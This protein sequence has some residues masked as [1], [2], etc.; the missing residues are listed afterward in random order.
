MRK[1]DTIERLYLDFDGFFASVE[2][3]ARPR[4]RGRP[5]GIVPFAGTR[6]TCVIACSKEAKA[7]GVKNVMAVAE[8]LR[9]C[10]DMVLAPQSPDL[11]R[12]AHNALLSEIAAVIPIAAVKSID[13]LTCDLESRDIRDPEGLASRIKRR[14]RDHVGP[15][16]TCSIG[17]AANRQLAKIAGKM[18]KP[19]GVTIWRPQD[20][21]G[22]LLPVPFAKIPGIGSR[23]E[24]R[25]ALAG[26]FDTAGLLALQ[27]KQMRKLWN[28][29]TGERLWYALHGYD[30]KT[31]PSRRGMFG[32]GRVLPP[33]LRSM[34]HARVF[35]RLLL[36]KAARRMRRAG[37]LAGRLWLWL[38][39][40]EDRWFG[41]WTLPAVRDDRACLVALETLWTQARRALPESARII[42][43]GVTLLDLSPASERQ[44]DLFLNDDRER[45]RWET[46]SAAMDRL[47]A[48]YGKTV[49][50]IGPWTPPPGG[51]AG[52]KI[53]Y[54][55]IPQAEDF[56]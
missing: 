33:A 53:S 55:R 5:V 31:P 35:S 47:N 20:M 42:R 27:P 52:G 23:M 19:D 2:Q 34:A 7:R 22:P 43:I 3:Q 56:W 46:L 9:I 50:S 11:Y 6:S 1:P 18:N 30:V 10:P 24:R 44:L 36:V 14:I 32:H 40:R 48:R 16:I 28:N 29:V 39:M 51:H 49:L 25:L 21:P 4:L 45:R 26:V 13:E 54:T 8:A 37:F 17:F 38:A 12:R 15:Y 41:Q